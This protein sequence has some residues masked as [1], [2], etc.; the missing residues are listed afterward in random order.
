MGNI[1][2]KQIDGATVLPKDDAILYDLIVGQSG[3][4]YGCDVSWIGGNQIHISAGYGIIRGRVFEI[5]EQTIYAKLSNTS[6]ASVYGALYIFL[7]LEDTD[8]PIC[9]KT[10]ISTTEFIESNGDFEQDENVNYINGMWSLVIAKYEATST[11]ITSFNAVWEKVTGVTNAIKSMAEWS[12]VTENGYLVD[13]LLEKKRILTFNNISVVTS[14][15]SSDDTYEDYPYM[16][17]IPLTGVDDNYSVS[18]TFGLAD[19]TSGMFAPIALTQSGSVC[20]YANS[21]PD[22]KVIIPTIQCIRKVG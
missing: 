15:W 8:N 1:S 7:D 6:N 14:A 12:A 19:A 18:V 21:M 16:A 2:L 4:I 13:A 17:A 5:E 9:I 3:Y 10:S 11:A 20:I 22:E